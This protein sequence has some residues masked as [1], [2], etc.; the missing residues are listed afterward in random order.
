[1]KDILVYVDTGSRAAARIDLAIRLAQRFGAHLTGLHVV[2]P[3]YVPAMTNLPVPPD[4][5]EDQVALYRDLAAKAKATF[6]AEVARA[7]ITGE[8]RAVDG[9]ADVLV[10]VHA[11]H[12]ALTVLGQA[13]PDEPGSTP[14]DLPDRVALGAGGPVLVVPRAG[15]FEDVGNRVV[16]AWNATREAKRALDDALPLLARAKQVTVLAIRPRTG[17]TKH[18]DVP[19]ADIAL[20]LARHGVKAEAAQVHA[21][22]MAV[23]DLL[24]SRTADLGADLIVMGAYGHPRLLEMTLGGTTRAILAHMTVPV[25]L[26]H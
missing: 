22:D 16:V 17:P 19:G 9:E 5:I 25:L 3:P 13:D 12:A 24:L 10:P 1:M 11:R 20:Y 21:E 14:G 4:I 8:W 7:G 26:S 23:P 6:E 18:G 15:T 2:P